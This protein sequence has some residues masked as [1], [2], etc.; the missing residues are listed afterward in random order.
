MR[1]VYANV[2]MS[3]KSSHTLRPVWARSNC[4]GQGWLS[5]SG[6]E[7]RRQRQETR[8]GC[9]DLLCLSACFV[10]MQYRGEGPRLVMHWVLVFETLWH[11]ACECLMLNSTVS[12]V[13]LGETTEVR[14]HL[15]GLLLC[16][17]LSCPPRNIHASQR[18]LYII[19]QIPGMYLHMMIWTFRFSGK[20]HNI[21]KYI[22]PFNCSTAR[23]SRW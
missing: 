4:S 13:A 7:V 5:L 11:Q 16:A 18:L 14:K 2:H 17:H 8:P 6:V 9:L 3:V 20:N 15:A 10:T 22:L 19:P 12:I 21:K 1:C 23:S